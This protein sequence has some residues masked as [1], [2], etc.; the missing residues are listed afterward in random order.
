MSVVESVEKTGHRVC[1]DRL[2]VV[3]RTSRV[4]ESVAKIGHWAFE[5]RLRIVLRKSKVVESVAKTGHRALEAL[6]K[7]QPS[8]LRVLARK[9][10]IKVYF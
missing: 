2:R 6:W 3:L 8:I 4:V 5:D 1:G 9:R 10:T 7:N